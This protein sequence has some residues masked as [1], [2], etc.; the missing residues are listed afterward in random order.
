MKKIGGTII[1]FL[2]IITL[3]A[4]NKKTST[5]DTTTTAPTTTEEP[6]YKLELTK[7]IIDAGTISGE[8]N[9]KEGSQVTISATTNTGYSFVGWYNGDQELTKDKAYSLTMPANN[10]KYEAKFSINKYTV[11][12]DNQVTGLN[13]TGVTSGDEYDYNSM[14]ELTA[15]NVSEGH[16]VKWIRSDN[17]TYIGNS[18]SFTLPAE[19]ISI[20]T[21]LLDYEVDVENNTIKFGYYPQTRERDNNIITQLNSL[22]GTTPTTDNDYNW[23]DYGYY[24][25]DSLDNRKNQLMWYI[26]LDTNSDGI[27]DYRGIYIRNYRT[28]TI[29]SLGS[30]SFYSYQD[31]NGYSKNN[32][33]WFKY[34]KIKWDVLEDNNDNYVIISNLAIDSQYYAASGNSYYSSYIRTFL[35]DNF[36]NVAFTTE[37]KAIMSKYV[38]TNDYVV[39]LTVNE[40]NNYY[41]NE[42]DRIGYASDYAKSQN[43]TPYDSGHTRILT[44]S[45]SGSS[46][47]NFISDNG[48]ISDLSAYSTFFG[49]KPVIILQ[50]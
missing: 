38:D 41:P 10:L 32:V 39:I 26:D 44:K 40:I 21:S 45:P 42:T 49:I 24:W 30:S 16:T 2:A 43:A 46:K 4:C 20:T 11:T 31:D 5:N 23:S 47:V 37:E 18:Y 3:F 13:V 48:D 22:A 17:I 36:Y 28:N 6:K 33:Y 29:S 8:N 9:Y 15:E 19:D 50:K 34:E 25:I 1:A 27:N 7:N 12:I 14:I 35:N